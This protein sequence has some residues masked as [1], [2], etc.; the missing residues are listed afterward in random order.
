MTNYA[1]SMM[2]SQELWKDIHDQAIAKGISKEEASKM[3]TTKAE[4]FRFANKINFVTDAIA[5]KGLVTGKSLASGAAQ[6]G[7]NK[8]NTLEKD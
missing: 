7:S 3:A 1:E 2:M 4:E 8:E 6:V 5:L